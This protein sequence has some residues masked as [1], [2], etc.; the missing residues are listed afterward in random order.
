M[1]SR[2]V[3]SYTHQTM[4][5]DSPKLFI[6]LFYRL[7]LYKILLCSVASST[8]KLLLTPHSARKRKTVEDFCWTTFLCNKLMIEMWSCL[9]Y[10]S[11]I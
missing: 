7:Q 10:F 5:M 1:T 4:M 11:A 3:L 2:L 8:R 9:D 6:N